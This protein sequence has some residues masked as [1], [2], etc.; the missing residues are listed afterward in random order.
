M[1]KKVTFQTEKDVD[2]ALL[3]LFTESYQPFRIV[4][5]P[6]FKKFVSALNPTHELPSRFT[7]SKTLIPALYEKCKIKLTNKILN[8][9]QTC[10]LTTDCWS[11]INNESYIAVTIHF[12]NSTFQLESALLACSNIQGSH[13]AE[14]LARELRKIISEWHLKTLQICLAVSDSAYNIWHTQLI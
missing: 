12:I 7:I 6:A 11:S 13:T 2:E 8:D 4:E 5:E 14:N 10:C 1:P 3:G 9:L